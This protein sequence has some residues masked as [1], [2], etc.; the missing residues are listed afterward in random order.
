MLGSYC[1]SPLVLVYEVSFWPCFEIDIS[2]E[3]YISVS[4]SLYSG[5]DFRIGLLSLEPAMVVIIAPKWR[6]RE[7]WSRVFYNFV[8]KVSLR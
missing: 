2:Y 7:N 4:I 1:K 3:N 8:S 6:I 5:K